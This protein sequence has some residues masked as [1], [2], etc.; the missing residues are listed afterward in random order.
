MYYFISNNNDNIFVD[1]LIEDQ[2]EE[3]R[4]L[5][6]G[7][8]I[9]VSME[10]KPDKKMGIRYPAGPGKSKGRY[11]AGTP[12]KSL[13]DDASLNSYLSQ[14]NT[15]EL[16]GFISEEEKRFSAA[17]TD[18]FRG[19]VK[20]DGKGP[21]HYELIMPMAKL[22]LRN[23]RDSRGAMPFTLGIEYGPAS[24]PELPPVLL[25]IRNIKLASNK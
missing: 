24:Q 11:S 22:P 7:L 6:N 14:A 23:S 18:N 2:G 1:L 20:L 5:K 9:W 3:M 17:N 13:S 25:W 12:E 21:L 15:I 16:I 19:S 10:S 4:I 8:T